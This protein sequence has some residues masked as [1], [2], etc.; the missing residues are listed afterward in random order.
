M[1]FWIKAVNQA[2]APEWSDKKMGFLSIMNIIFMGAPGAGKGTQADFVCRERKI[3]QVSTGEILREAVKNKTEQGMR[4]KNYMDAGNL[5]PDEV[6]ISIIEERIQKEDCKKGFLLDG[7]PRTREQ[8]ESLDLILEKLAQSIHRVLFF[9]VEDDE[10]IKRLLKRAKTGERSDDNMESIQNRLKVFKEKT[11]PV[12]D[13]YENKNI[14]YRISG[15]G[16]IK[17]ISRKVQAI[18]ES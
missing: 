4:A 8:A 5:L 18:L 2:R 15:M 10:L 7:F 14:L 6:M 12:L 3:A 16:K 17:D 9:D 11:K 1:A 13:Y